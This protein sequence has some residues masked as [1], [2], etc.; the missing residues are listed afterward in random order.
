MKLDKLRSIKSL[1]IKFN[2]V[3]ADSLLDPM[4]T[5][6]Q[7]EIT[8]QVENALTYGMF[9]LTGN[10]RSTNGTLTDAL[11]AQANLI[12]FAPR[13]NNGW[14]SF[15]MEH[16]Y[17]K[18]DFSATPSTPGEAI[19]GNVGNLTCYNFPIG[20]E[21]CQKLGTV[22][23]YTL[24]P[25]VT[26][27]DITDQNANIL[28]GS[29]QITAEANDNGYYFPL[30]ID[31]NI[32]R[33]F[34]NG[35]ILTDIQY[36][37]NP[38]YEFNILEDVNLVTGQLSTLV[39]LNGGSNPY[40]RYTGTQFFSGFLT[41]VEAATLPQSYFPYIYPELKYIVEVNY[42]TG[43]L[44]FSYGI[45]Y[46]NNLIYPATIGFKI[47]RNGNT[48][49]RPIFPNT[50][51]SA[52]RMELLLSDYLTSNYI[53]VQPV[54]YYNAT[55]IGSTKFVIA[56]DY[57]TSIQLSESMNVLSDQSSLPTSSLE[58]TYIKKKEISDKPCEAC[59]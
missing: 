4:N 47:L 5:L 32:T 21:S 19:F 18:T 16:T 26:T 42:N 54:I 39:N 57:D 29:F 30:F 46:P 11:T 7:S 50:N 44:T 33:D 20:Y 12:V 31:V 10:G 1:T 37:K 53:E 58:V 2:T 49:Q 41:K 38:D 14:S 15:L 59:R 56:F 40:T 45:L 35:N 6:K 17:T 27:S 51:D 34:S 13:T 9:L 23:L 28:F 8:L 52:G 55:Y 48:I 24:Y 43:I 25:H 3:K 22:G 36:L